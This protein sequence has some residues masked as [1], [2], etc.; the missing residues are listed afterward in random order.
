MLERDEKESAV[1]EACREGPLF[2]ERRGMAPQ[3]TV[4]SKSEASSVNKRRAV[5]TR[6]QE[7]PPPLQEVAPR[8]PVISQRH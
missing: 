6:F 1:V 8:G 4:S 3:A 7:L 2:K 5:N